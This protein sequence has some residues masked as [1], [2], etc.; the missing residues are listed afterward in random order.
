[1]KSNSL[2]RRI[3]PQGSSGVSCT[4]ALLVVDDLVLEVVLCGFVMSLFPSGQNFHSS[5]V[6]HGFL[7]VGTQLS[8]VFSRPLSCLLLFRRPPDI[9]ATG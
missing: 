8:V 6:R 2:L 9:T 1:M 3:E 5:D 4:T 7:C